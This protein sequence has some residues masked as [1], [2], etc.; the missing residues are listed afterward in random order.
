MIS[1]VS[2]TESFDQN[3]EETI[4]IMFFLQKKTV[5]FNLIEN[6]QRSEHHLGSEYCEQNKGTFFNTS[7]MEW[8]TSGNK[9]LLIQ[10]QKYEVKMCITHS[11][12]IRGFKRPHCGIFVAF[13]RGPVKLA[14][15]S[16][17]PFKAI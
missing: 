17:V 7:F 8:I 15:L 9:D 5:L 4:L 6:C 3:D 16:G 12:D 1:P 2:E 10:L 13:V 14:Q 11:V